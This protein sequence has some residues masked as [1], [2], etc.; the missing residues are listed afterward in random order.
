MSHIGVLELARQRLT[1]NFNI[2]N[3]LHQF[4]LNV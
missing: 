3:R 2:N 4:R 1:A